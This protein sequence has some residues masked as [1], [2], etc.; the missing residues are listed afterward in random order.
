VENEAIHTN[1]YHVTNIIPIDTDYVW[2]HGD[3]DAILD[4]NAL[5]IIQS[6]ASSPTPP[7][8]ILFPQSKRSTNSQKKYFGTLYELCNK[9]GFHEML[10][11]MSQLIVSHKEFKQSIHLY[12]EK[13]FQVKKNSD[14]TY[15]RFSAFHHSTRIFQLL[16]SE[17]A[18]F[19][20]QSIIDEQ[21]VANNHRLKS[22]TDE[23]TRELFFFLVE[24]FTK[25]IR[26]H[27]NTLSPIFLRYVN[28]S[29]SDLL[30]NITADDIINKNQTLLPIAEKIDLI[31]QLLNLV[32][33]CPM[34][35]ISIGHI[36]AI[37]AVINNDCTIQKNDSLEIIQ[38]IYNK[39]KISRYS[40]IITHETA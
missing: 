37:K 6:I 19:L 28:K 22:K 4:S 38:G 17:K 29:F 20:D 26:F 10:G 2:L 13:L 14:L 8:I 18:V 1:W 5:N 16:S 39:T 24:D 36:E 25:I 35:K 30:L 27:P 12:A 34:K 40:F 7:K 15:S 11:W 21:L 23:N 3:D 31:E 33:D 9:Y 32:Y